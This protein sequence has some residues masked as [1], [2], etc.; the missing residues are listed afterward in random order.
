MYFKLILETLKL[1][2]LSCSYGLLIK[3]NCVQY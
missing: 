1:L 3:N 2:T